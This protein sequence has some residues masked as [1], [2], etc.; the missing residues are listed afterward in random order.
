MRRMR[1]PPEMW[2]LGGYAVLVT[3]TNV[4]LWRRMFDA[5]ITVQFKDDWIAELNEERA[6]LNSIINTLEKK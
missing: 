5:E 1:M 3:I 4:F 6:H 2:I